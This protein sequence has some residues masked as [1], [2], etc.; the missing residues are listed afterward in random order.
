LNVSS[1]KND[2]FVILLKLSSSSSSIPAYLNASLSN[3][4]SKLWVWVWVWVYLVINK[5]TKRKRFEIN[6]YDKNEYKNNLYVYNWRREAA[7]GSS[8]L[9]RI[10][11]ANEAV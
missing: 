2:Q 8:V 3:D 1:I 4:L 5:Y 9:T 11:T 7:S 6:K 10:T